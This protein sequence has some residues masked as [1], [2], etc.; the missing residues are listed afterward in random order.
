VTA[1]TRESPGPRPAS[2]GS[3]GG[4]D[5][6]VGQDAARGRFVI[7]AAGGRVGSNL[8]VTALDAHPV[9]GC[10]WEIFN[11]AHFRGVDW[12][13]GARR[14]ASVLEGIPRAVAGF[15]LFAEQA[16]R[17][18][19]RSV[20]TW[21]EAR[22]DVRIVHLG[23]R[24]RLAQYV[25]LQAALRTRVWGHGPADRP[26]PV[27][28]CLE[29]R[30]CVEWIR[31]TQDLDCELGARFARHA[32]LA[33]EYERDIAGTTPPPALGRV[34]RFLGLPAPSLAVTTRKSAVGPLAER[35]RNLDEVLRALRIHGLG[36]VA[37]EAEANAARAA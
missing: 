19:S 1:P 5:G 30:A 4:R 35:V 16:R 32:R 18:P 21:L 22:R 31:R 9:V 25:S 29:P 36:S 12:I 33:L 17:G 10:A 26:E 13:D 15:K 3:A 2:E 27:R 23:R 24:D 7:V 20:W 8:L 6:S 14:A 11:P 37:E 34:E 28:L